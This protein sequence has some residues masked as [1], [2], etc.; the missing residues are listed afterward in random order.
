[1]ISRFMGKPCRVGGSRAGQ[2]WRRLVPHPL[3]DGDRR[4]LL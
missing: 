2:W 4:R 3:P 1:M